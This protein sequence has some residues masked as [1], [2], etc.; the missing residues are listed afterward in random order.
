M[1]PAKL[2]EL[3]L[4]KNKIIIGTLGGIFLL[5][6]IIFIYITSSNNTSVNSNNTPSDTVP[7]QTQQIGEEVTDVTTIPDVTKTEKE[8]FIGDRKP[9]T[10]EVLEIVAN[11]K[12]EED[13]MAVIRLRITGGEVQD[14][15]SDPYIGLGSCGVAKKFLPDSVCVDVGKPDPFTEGEVI[16]RITIK[17]DD[18]ENQHIYRSSEDGYYNG[19]EFTSNN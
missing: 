7:T 14:V 15:N 19:I 4:S 12:T 18:S 3:I 17:W 10:T 1:M 5:L 2:N 8:I 13:R 11:K 16:V 9:G 6:L